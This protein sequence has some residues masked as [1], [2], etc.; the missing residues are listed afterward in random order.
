[1]TGLLGYPLIWLYGKIAGVAATWRHPRHSVR[2]ALTRA[3]PRCQG[4]ARFRAG[5]GGSDE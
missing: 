2:A 3:H 5:W 1:M 4:C